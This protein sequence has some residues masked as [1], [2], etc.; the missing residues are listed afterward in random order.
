MP[1]HC[2][3]FENIDI[4]SPSPRLYIHSKRRF[5]T[6]SGIIGSAHLYLI[7]IGIA[8]YFFI[9]FLLGT[10]MTIIYSKDE[11]SENFYF[12]LTQ[13]LIALD[14]R[15]LSFGKID[16]RIAY[17]YP[18]LWEY[19][20]ANHNVTPIP[21]ETC[22]F[23]KHFPKS[24][25]EKAFEGLNVTDS[26][27]FISKGLDIS[28]YFN[29]T[30]WSGSFIIIYLRTCTNSTENN[31]HCYPQEEIDK[32]MLNESYYLSFLLETTKINH[33]NHSSPFEITSFYQ[34]IKLSYEARFDLN[35]Y[36]S[37]IEYNTDKGWLF[38]SIKTERYYK[39][40]QSLTTTIS[41]AASQHYY[42]PNTF[43]KFQLGLNYSTKEKYKRT[44]PKIQS[45]IANISGLIQVSFQLTKI[46]IRLL[47]AGQ[48]FSSFFDCES[49]SSP[50]FISLSSKNSNSEKRNVTP[51]QLRS[52]TSNISIKKSKNKK[53]R[54]VT[55][56]MSLKWIMVPKHFKEL[57]FISDFENKIKSTLSIDNLFKKL[58]Y[59]TIQS[60]SNSSP[61]KEYIN[62][63]LSRNKSY[64]KECLLSH[65]LSNINLSKSDNNKKCKSINN[66]I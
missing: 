5:F 48:Y 49:V 50:K 12:N 32:A 14:F 36:Y 3:S 27:C 30:D 6:L 34:Q 29:K 37:P 52:L 54:N 26:K 65:S 57:K 35:V 10:G 59:N 64:S 16:S 60:T 21:L 19:K 66:Y 55:P 24:K 47:T 4:L 17:L 18:V 2:Y 23:D 1:L 43:S 13:K 45:V 62:N 58:V 22:Q 44:Y 7:F 28:L 38:E 51:I 41:V 11:V 20:G 42:Y 40:D 8:L 39:V 61:S 53:I 15:S 56:L 31:N 33:Y 25:Y 46:F 9:D 63:N